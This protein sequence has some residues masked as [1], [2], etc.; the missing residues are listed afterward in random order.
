MRR[1]N[2]HACAHTLRDKHLD[3]YSTN[4]EL[5]LLK[6]GITYPKKQEK[7]EESPGRGLQRHSHEIIHNHLAGNW[8]TLATY[9]ERLKMRSKKLK[10]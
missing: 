7:K 1:H 6:Q 4:L 8:T 2:K 9:S 10:S 3:T 5:K